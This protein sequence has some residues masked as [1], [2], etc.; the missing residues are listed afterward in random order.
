MNVNEI[1]IVKKDEF[2]SYTPK[3]LHE[4]FTI[5]VNSFP[6]IEEEHYIIEDG[7]I[8]FNE[9]LSIGDKI[10]LS[11]SILD[12][13]KV[14]T[15]NRYSQNCLLKMY[16]SDYKFK[17]NHTYNF[18]LILNETEYTSKFI[19]KHDPCYSNVKTIRIDMGEIVN[20]V[21]DTVINL[22]I[23]KNSKAVLERVT[24]EDDTIPTYIKNYVRYTTC[25]DLCQTVY[26]SI[27]GKY[28]SRSKQIDGIKIDTE[29]KLPYV[30]EMM[31]RFKELLLP[32]EDLING[33][34]TVLATGFVK[35]GST[36]YPVSTRS[37]F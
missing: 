19:T 15:K 9:N 12:S 20:S 26:L 13:T 35:A 17:F 18:S 24:I 31:A 4:E 3:I 8:I 10:V 34:D 6:L 16:T 25:L 22:L 37:S 14:I 27:T 33:E 5:E 29:I 11:S 21:N 2:N 32:I 1:Y 30:K 7:S 28:G 23:Y 36:E